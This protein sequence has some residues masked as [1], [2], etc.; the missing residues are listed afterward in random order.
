[1]L[2][3]ATEELAW[4]E[5]D[6]TDLRLPPPS[7]SWRVAEIFH[8]KEPDAELFWIIGTDQW[9]D[10]D[11]WGRRDYL[12]SLVTFIVYQRDGE[13]A[14]PREDIRAI[15]VSGDHPVSSTSIRENIEKALRDELIPAHVGTYIRA[16]GL[17]GTEG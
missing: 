10:I 3:L 13:K 14:S 8:E 16:H 17:Y 6:E 1:M 2:H 7:W 5:V 12:A 9:L 15:F 11:R 4:A